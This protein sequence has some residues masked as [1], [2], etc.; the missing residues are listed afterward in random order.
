M[1]TRLEG[2]LLEKAPEEITVDV[3]GVG[4]E[5]RVPLSTFLAL[6]DEGK[7]VCMRIH[8]H[9][10]EE[11]F[12]LY[13]FLRE[14][15]R[16]CFRMLLGIN[17]IGP[18]LAL[19]ILAGLPVERLLGAIRGGELAVLVG[20]PGVGKKT[21]ERMLIE[22]RDTVGKLDPELST[23]RPRDG[24]E[25]ACLSALLNLGCP[26][27]HAEKAVRRALEGLSEDPLLE[28]LIK[29]ALSVAAG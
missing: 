25:A 28:D 17:G 24:V 10:R 1:I 4:Y 9:V 20:I 2:V 5:V 6:P 11:A 13:G 23:A 8:T 14:A 15:E 21:A 19:S 26:R 16:Q 7:N 29:E 12:H 3:N 18:R 27:A 22:L